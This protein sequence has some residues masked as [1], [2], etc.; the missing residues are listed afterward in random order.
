MVSK[1]KH[2]SNY[3]N[4]QSK[5]ENVTIVLQVKYETKSGENIYV[6]GSSDKFG[7]WKSPVFK[8]KWSANHIWQGELTLPRSTPT[9]R[10]KFV[11]LGKDEVK[12]WEEGTD[13]LLCPSLLDNFF[14][15]NGKYVIDCIWNHFQI[16]FN[17]YF[18]LNNKDE[19]FQI[20][21]EPLALADWQRNGS[22][23]VQMDL[24]EEKSIIAKDGN[25]IHGRF[26]VVTV[27]MKSDDPRNFCFE[28]RYSI[29]NSV[30]SMIII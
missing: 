15:K 1:D 4:S 21:G 27:L 19:H 10:Y 22:K 18:P 3:Y 12:R 8:L 29:N 9:I 14:F 13:R 24:S 25:D 23:P 20:V 16:T 7:K 6:L 28:Y 11:C 17:I 5:D 30:T 2:S 26:W